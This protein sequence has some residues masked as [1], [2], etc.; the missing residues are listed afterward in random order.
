MKNSDGKY[1][2]IVIY[3]S[4]SSGKTTFLETLYLLCK[5]G[6]KKL[7]PSEDLKKIEMATGRT[8]YFDKAVFTLE[9]H[10][11]IFHLFTVAGQSRWKPLRKKVLQGA[12]Y[13]IFVVDSQRSRIPDNVDSLKE[14]RRILKEN[15]IEKT[16][17]LLIMNK[18]DLDDIIS[19]DEW[20]GIMEDEG[21]F[22]S[23]GLLVTEEPIGFETVAIFE[24]NKNIYESIIEVIRRIT[25][26]N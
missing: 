11:D 6:D 22:L 18:Q 12:H 25:E 2:K 19:L 16:P 10:N 8:I 14:L 4:V 17:F 21:I 23:D 20:K 5:E 9:D 26:K 1:N 7:K 13:I 15:N 3:G 24:E